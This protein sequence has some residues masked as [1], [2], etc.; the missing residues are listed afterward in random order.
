MTL[1][2]VKNQTLSNYYE[3]LFNLVN[4]PIIVFDPVNYQILTVNDKACKVYQMNR[5][6]LLH[7]SLKKFWHGGDTDSEMIQVL[8][9]EGA[10]EEFET[11]HTLSDGTN[12]NLL[13]SLSLVEYEGK[14]AIISINH[15]ITERY[16]DAVLIQ[17]AKQEWSD[18]V[19]A[20]TDLIILEDADGKLRRCNKATSEFFGLP[21]LE[22]IEQPIETLIQTESYLTDAED[23]NISSDPRH[24]RDKIWD[25]QI[26][27]RDNWFEITNHPIPS[28]TEEKSRWVHIIKDTTQR[29]RADAEL[30]RLYTAIEQAADAFI[31]TDLSGLVQYVNASF[32]QMSGFT[33]AEA[34]DQPISKIKENIYV[35]EQIN[36][37]FFALARGETWQKTYQVIRRNGEIYNEQATVSLLKDVDGKPLNYVFI[38]RDI[39]ETRRLESIAEAVNMMDNVGYI[40][41]GIRHELGN[42][43]N[44]VKMAL[45]VLKN[46]LDKWERDQINVYIERCLVETAR[47]EFMLRALRTFG[48]HENPKMQAVAMQDYM[49]NFVSLIKEDFSGRN[50]EII[51]RS[52]KEIG[53]ALCDPRALHQVMLNLLAN[54]ADA[55]DGRY[56]PLIEIFV[57]RS[58]NLIYVTVEDNGMGMSDAQLKHLFK[59]FHSSKTEGTGLGLVIVRK[60]LV[61]MNGTIEVESTKNIGTK[62][63]FTLETA[64]NTI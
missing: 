43:I 8:L 51:L 14:Q 3:K 2:V 52:D 42:P 36:D 4:D 62:V 7:Q 30:Q 24:L 44:S 21:Y 59:P 63:Q 9:K 32:E 64:E 16:R 57:T 34:L 49:E 39:T 45:T 22:L 38:C 6:N 20:V 60:T 31:I 58:K 1:P 13:V 29:K 46:N 48:M 18:T 11:V 15:D 33:R 41:S 50:I 40:F 35:Y 25:G 55:L 19:D 28:E 56:K 23:K 61:R 17:R 53:S 5:K 37:I 54:A 10:V 27:G 47:V 12:M 26:I